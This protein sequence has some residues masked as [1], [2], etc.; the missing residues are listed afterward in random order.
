MSNQA[1]QD[2]HRGYCTA[3][4]EANIPVRPE[5]MLGGDFTSL[6]GYRAIRRALEKGLE[7]SAVFAA[8]DEMAIGIIA[9][10]EDAGLKVPVDVSVVGFDDL[11]EIGEELTTIRQDIAKLAAT[12]VT[13]LKE[14]LAGKPVRQERLPVQLIVRGT[15]TRRR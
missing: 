8:S 10:L 12:T 6:G 13:L 9:A 15:T 4:E 3:L 7:F 2:R 14:G 5:L 11:P 1:F